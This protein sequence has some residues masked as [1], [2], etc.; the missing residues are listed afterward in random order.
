MKGLIKLPC[1]KNNSKP[2]KKKIII[3]GIIQNFFLDIKNFKSS[4]K[5][6]I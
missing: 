5:V 2:N 4:I 3:I 1:D 6:D